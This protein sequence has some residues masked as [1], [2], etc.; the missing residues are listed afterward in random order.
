MCLRPKRRSAMLLL[1]LVAAASGFQSIR[2]VQSPRSFQLRSQPKPQKDEIQAEL[3]RL[4]EEMAQ[5]AD[6]EALAPPPVD[7]AFAPFFMRALLPLAY[8]G[9]AAA[10]L[11]TAFRLPRAEGAAQVATALAAVVDFEPTAQRQL[12]SAERA[13]GWGGANGDRWARVVRAKIVGQLVGL[14][15]AASGR[16]LAGAAVLAAADVRFWAS[17]AGACRFD[18][19]GAPAPV[20]DATA[21]GLLGVNVFLCGAAALASLGVLRPLGAA[22][23]A[24]L[25]MLQ[26]VGDEMTRRRNPKVTATF[27]LE[28]AVRDLQVPPSPRA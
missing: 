3:R 11:A 10:A 15:V 5:P 8:R 17:G 25:V 21:R 9:L 2:S 4:A 18:E 12:A 27:D 14:A 6:D 7:L 13:A 16:A 22:I 26:T 24:S 19:D 28:Q 20:A 23:Y 1:A